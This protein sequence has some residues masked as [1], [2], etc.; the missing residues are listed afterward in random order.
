MREELDSFIHE[1]KIL[2][3]TFYLSGGDR[4][5]TRLE[6]FLRQFLKI[7][8][9]QGIEEA[10]L[11]FEKCTEE[12]Q[13]SFQTIALLEGIKLAS[14]I[15]VF[16]GIH[17][18]PLPSSKS[19]FPTYFGSIPSPKVT[20]YFGK[21]LLVTDYSIFPIFHKPSSLAK[22]PDEPDSYVLILPGIGSTVPTHVPV[23][24][25]KQRARFKVEV[26][27]GKFPDFK[28]VDFYSNF[29]QALS[30]ACNSAVQ[31]GMRWN[32]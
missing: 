26:D 16:E 32:L 31:I 21:T 9:V 25:A 24:W 1:D 2:S 12:T 18:I 6:D 20:N 14:E 8:I 30:L 17:L 29:C 10:V 5:G 13:G 11:N 23:E 22:T 7:A 4:H 27:G 3:A 15:Q 19:E 28:E